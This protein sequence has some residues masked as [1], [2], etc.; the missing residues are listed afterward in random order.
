MRFLRIFSL[1]LGLGGPVFFGGFLWIGYKQETLKAIYPVEAY[2]IGQNVRCSENAPVW[3]SSLARDAL[4]VLK[5][6]S[7]QL[8]L[9]DR[10]GKVSHCE[11]GWVGKGF[12]LV[13]P[14]TRFR[15]GSLTK[16]ITSAQ[17]LALVS[18]HQLSLNSSLRAMLLDDQSWGGIKRPSIADVTLQELLSHRSGLLSDGGLFSRKP[19]GAWCPNDLNK[20]LKQKVHLLEKARYSNLGYCL[21]GAIIAELSGSPY[22]RVVDKSFHLRERGMLFAKRGYY[23]DEVRYDYRFND[24]Y[25]GLGSVEYDYGAIASTAG[26]TGSALAYARLVRDILDE[27]YVSLWLSGYDFDSCSV[28]ELRSCYGLAFYFYHPKKREGLHVKEGYL[29]GAASFVVVNED[30]EVMVWVGNSDT[31]NAYSGAG[32]KS[33]LNM[34][35]AGSWADVG[36]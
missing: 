26:L 20:L 30:H 1:L 21:A 7:T 9:I 23:E 35:P 10:Y 4:S 13:A 18:N 15:Y 11:T 36:E 24:F 34:L 17:L 25:G 2:L 28:Q 3:F 14:E 12:G 16:P 32:I 33:V 22:Q 29:P 5:A 19:G 6:L 31:D 8:V 27:E